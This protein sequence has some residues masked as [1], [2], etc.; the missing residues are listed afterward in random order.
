MK[1]LALVLALVAGAPAAHASAQATATLTF[2]RYLDRVMDR[3]LDLAAT[4]TD[5]A[6]AEARVQVGARLPEP[7]LSVGL[8]SFDVS[9]PTRTEMRQD[10][11][12]NGDFVCGYHTGTGGSVVP[13]RSQLPTVV[14]ASIDVPIE[15]GDQQGARMDVARVGV[16]Q[17]DQDVEDAIR[18]LRGEAA[19]VWIDAL[20]TQLRLE[21]LQRTLASLEQLVHTNEA[22]VEAGAIGDIELVQS[23]VEAQMFRAQVLRAE[24]EARAARMGLA[25]LL[26]I[27]DGAEP[28]F[29][30]AGTLSIDPRTF[31]LDALVTH[32]METRP[33]LRRIQLDIDAARASRSL[34]ERQRWGTLDVSLSW[35]Y[36]TPGTDTQF[37]QSDYHALGLMFG[38]PLPF[39]LLWSGE[40]DEA[41]SMESAADQRYQQAR[42][43]LE[44][45]IRQA[46]ARYEASV[47]ARQVF[48]L[49][50][51]EDAE[52]V[53]EATRYQYEHG[54]ATLVA[55]LVA[56]RTVN[57]VY[58]AY[59]EALATHAHALVDLETAAGLW[60]VSFDSPPAAAPPPTP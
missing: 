36:S 33:D 9:H 27:E 1:R 37:G 58:A 15:L 35:L 55:V 57:E 54:G 23:R 12:A 60:D 31:D 26:R 43:R 3:N 28:D 19:G 4:R 46:L 50:V 59:N 17:A 40:I 21:R 38:I 14:G 24:G 56:Q 29:A 10:T 22:R 42:Q 44:V 34:A 41:R 53:L 30:P 25:S 2:G 49:S 39:R 18:L 20:G 13:C 52:H 16:S 7:S 6:A 45:E 32:A 11:D 5:V 8:L 48:D 51:I 47:A